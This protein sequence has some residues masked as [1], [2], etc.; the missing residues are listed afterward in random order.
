MRLSDEPEARVPECPG[1]HAP[2]IL[3]APRGCS[4]DVEGLRL[5]TLCMQCQAFSRLIICEAGAKSA[6]SDS[7][8][9]KASGSCCCVTQHVWALVIVCDGSLRLCNWPEADA[10]EGCLHLCQ[11][12]RAVLAKTVLLPCIFCLLSQVA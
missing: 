3:R 8:A 7:S 12:L 4:R 2:R 9:S 5:E 10:T 6:G 11:V 1:C